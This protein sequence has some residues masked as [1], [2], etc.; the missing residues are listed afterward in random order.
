MEKDGITSLK[1]VSQN[2]HDDMR[3]RMLMGIGIDIDKKVEEYDDTIRQMQGALGYDS[4]TIQLEVDSYRKGLEVGFQTAWI[5]ILNREKGLWHDV[6]EK[7]RYD[8]TVGALNQ[9]IVAGKNS[10]TGGLIAMSVGSMSDEDTLYCPLNDKEY[11]WGKCPFTK[12]AYAK[13][14]LIGLE[15]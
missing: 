2:L 4:Y 14:I 10:A 8:Y 7:P 3:R 5:Q 6:S 1:E 13:D 9:I 12:W 15:L 11:K